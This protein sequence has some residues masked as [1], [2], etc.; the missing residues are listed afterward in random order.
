MQC[1]A[2]QKILTAVEALYLTR[3]ETLFHLKLLPMDMI[4]DNHGPQVEAVGILF[5]TLA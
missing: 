5:L 3:G 2:L 4:I 1:I